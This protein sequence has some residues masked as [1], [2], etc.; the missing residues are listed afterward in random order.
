M[1]YSYNRLFL[2]MYCCTLP[3]CGLIYVLYKYNTFSS[4]RNRTL[5]I[6]TEVHIYIYTCTHI[7]YVLK[8]YVQ[9]WSYGFCYI[10]NKAHEET[11]YINLRH[12]RIYLLMIFMLLV[13][14]YIYLEWFF[15]VSVSKLCNI[16]ALHLCEVARC[17]STNICMLST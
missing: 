7:C 17:W 12:V 3:A 10:Y 14:S 11:I 6:I 15:W 2:C 4:K 13:Y 8:V 16:I 9:L 1:F 5:F